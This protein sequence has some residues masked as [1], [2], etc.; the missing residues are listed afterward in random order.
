MRFQE[1]LRRV[2]ALI[3]AGFY[4]SLV[5]VFALLYSQCFDDQFYHSTIQQEPAYERDKRQVESKLSDELLSNYRRAIGGSMMKIGDVTFEIT[6]AGT[7]MEF[8]PNG[9]DIYIFFHVLFQSSSGGQYIS[10]PLFTVDYPLGSPKIE[11]NGRVYTSHKIEAKSTTIVADNDRSYTLSA[12]QLFPKAQ[13]S[14]TSGPA[15]LPSVSTY[16]AMIDIKNASQGFPS[17]ISGDIWRMVYLSA[18][19]VTTTGFGDIVPLTNGAR[20]VVWIEAVLG[21]ILAGLFINSLLGG[22]HSEHGQEEGVR[23]D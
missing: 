5:P 4:S 2:P 10:I 14:S 12:E 13:E 8:R 19:T 1:R 6:G 21:I 9:V 20:T 22:E 11:G 17:E 16:N 3:W 23:S 7:Q 18:I 15:I